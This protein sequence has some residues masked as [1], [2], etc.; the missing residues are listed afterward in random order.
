M[1]LVLSSTVLRERITHDHIVAVA[2]IVGGL[3]LYAA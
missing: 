1:V 3:I 2:L